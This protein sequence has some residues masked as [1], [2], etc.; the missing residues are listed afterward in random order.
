M[1]HPAASDVQ[2]HSS[3]VS[4]LQTVILCAMAGGMGWGIRG[5]YGHES[6]AM[7][8]GL[9]VSSVIA[10][11]YCRGA[12]GPATLRAMA[13]CTIAIGF[14]GSMT[15]GQTV[16]LTHNP[17]LVGNNAAWTWGM[18][19]LAVKGGIWIGFA[20]V[21]LGMG[22]GG[23]QWSRTQ[24][25]LLTLAMIALYPVG[26]WLLNSPHDS[27]GNPLPAIYFS[28]HPQWG[29]PDPLKSRAEC[30]GGL[31][32]SLIG[33]LMIAGIMRRDQL[34]VRFGL[35]G[36]LGGAIGFPA[37]Q[38]FQSYHA[39]HREYFQTGIWQTLDPLINWWNLMEI[40]FGAVM[41]AAL[42]LA[43]WWN[44]KKIL[45][46]GSVKLADAPQSLWTDLSL[47]VLHLVLLSF[48][49][50]GSVTLIDQLY[51]IGICMGLIPL[52]ATTASRWWPGLLL[53]PVIM[54]PIAGKSVRRL[55]YEEQMFSTIE[56]WTILFA[57]PMIAGILL[58][59]LLSA[60]TQQ[61]LSGDRAGRFVLLYGSWMFFA[62]NFAFFNFPWPWKEWTA[63]VPSAIVF[64]VCLAGLTISA[65]RTAKPQARIS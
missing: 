42:G 57:V 51:G 37:G 55:V 17:V 31:L 29:L 52:M 7:M 20:G 41:G 16:G 12:D 6:G 5:Q 24:M 4:G 46:C 64:T 33:L 49:E 19:G 13:W 15:Y 25:L 30:W 40:T 26:I 14:G 45:S 63:R 27:S 21:F 34:A 59:V 3:R 28:S 56:G 23:T 39:W 48:S 54:L 18:L 1:N 44:Q 60:K 10:M 32:F 2:A 36:I 47:L 38:C 11:L 9:L 8:A 58:A 65:W 61:G 53:G 50:F 43:V 62:L 35:A 22:L